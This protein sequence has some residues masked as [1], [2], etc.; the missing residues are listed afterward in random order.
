M[1]VTA[2]SD[3]AVFVLDLAD[4]PSVPV[5]VWSLELVIPAA[6]L[7]FLLRRRRPKAAVLLLALAALLVC[8]SA[9]ASDP[10]SDV[11]VSL[12]SGAE[13][14]MIDVYYDLTHPSGDL[15]AVS[16]HLSKDGGAT[17][18]FP[19][20]AVSGDVG[21]GVA[22]GNRRHIV[23]NAMA[24]FPGEAI[25][26]AA[27][28]VTAAYDG[29][30]VQEETILLPGGASL[31]MVWI[32]GGTFLMG[33]YPGEQDSWD[34]LEDPQHSV[35]VPGFWMA[36]YELTK[37]QW[38]A[39][40]GT[41]PWSGQSDVLNDPDSPAVWVSWDDARALIMALNSYTG[42]T[43]RL[44]SEAEWEHACR[45]R[46]T[47]RFYWGDDP[48]YTVGNAYCWWSYNAHLVGESYA[49]VAGQ[50]LPNV[51]GL[52]DM[53]GNVWE[54]CEDDMHNDYTDAPT[55]GSAW[56]NS[57]RGLTR[58]LRGGA[59]GSAGLNSRSAIR[60]HISP[61]YT[62]TAFGFRLAR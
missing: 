56:V 15:S 27:V 38:Q 7:A 14:G 51:F 11:T 44:P 54:W 47:T 31:E 22:S 5:N 8:Q 48:S 36:K 57:P 20:T 23:W 19:C 60:F 46:T 1:G 32:P 50:K 28:R 53:S 12:R 21:P 13:R 55:D 29:P 42:K 33:R 16:L 17:F 37:R 3:S 35:T 62:A 58:V 34:D 9:V 41:T 45:A 61:S 24:D 6:G 49:H 25:L 39:I 52:Y 26:T 59:W 18:P 43:F 30:D 40:M 10:V 4:T 2:H